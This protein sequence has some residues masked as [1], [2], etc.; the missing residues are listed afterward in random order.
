MEKYQLNKTTSMILAKMNVPY[1]HTALFLLTHC[2][3]V[4][5]TFLCVTLQTCTMISLGKLRY[6][7]N[8]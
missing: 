6:L 5:V 2:P 4:Y 7:I 8:K 1:T 3:C